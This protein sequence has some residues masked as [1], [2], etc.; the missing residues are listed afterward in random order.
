MNKLKSRKYY[1]KHL[2][3]IMIYL[4]VVICDILFNYYMYI[5]N[6]HNLYFI[7]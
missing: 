5:L 2:N 6:K 7:F 1:V 4:L 3:G